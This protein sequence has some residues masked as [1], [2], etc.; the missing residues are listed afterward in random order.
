[1]EPEGHLLQH[2]ELEGEPGEGEKGVEGWGDGGEGWGTVGRDGGTV[3]RV[4]EEG[5]RVWTC[6]HEMKRPLRHPA[7]WVSLPD[8]PHVPAV[9]LFDDVV[10]APEHGEQVEHHQQARVVVLAGPGL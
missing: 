7:V 2:E 6:S 5:G 8:E 1:M 3:G 10:H 4:G 9:A